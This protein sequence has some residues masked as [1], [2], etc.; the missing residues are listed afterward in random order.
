MIPM[1]DMDDFAEKFFTPRES[2]YINALS[3]KQKEA[4]FFK[5]WTCKEAF[6]KANGSGL[7]VPINQVEI[8]LETK[9]APTLIS[10]GDD[11]KQNSHWRLEL[12]NSIP[13]YKAAVAIEGHDCQIIFQQLNN[14]PAA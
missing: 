13:G 7:T 9:D 12:L 14:H 2:E 5:T 11:K 4:A 10:I 1:A 8:S 3:G 6:L